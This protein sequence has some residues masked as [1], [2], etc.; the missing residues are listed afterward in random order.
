MRFLILVVT[1]LAGL[2]GGYWFI[3]RAAVANG[4]TALVSDLQ[5]RGW[6]VS[7]A[8]MATMG[9]PS[10]FDT[11]V[12]DLAVTDPATGAGW[13]APLFQVFALSYRPN[14]V[15]A[16]WPETQVIALPGQDV[17][18]TAADLRASAAVNASTDLAL[19]AVT[20]EG[21][22]IALASDLGWTAA[23]VRGLF[24]FRAAGPGPADYDLFTEATDLTLPAGLTARIDP[25]GTMPGVVAML[26]IDS[27]LTLDRP[28][29]RHL[30][31]QAAL[32]GVNLREMQLNWGTVTLTGNGTLTIDEAGVPDGRITLG[33]RNW[34]RLIALAVAA[35]VLDAGL[36]PTIGNVA[37][38][39]AAGGDTVS[40]PLSFQGGFMALGPLPLGPAPR[41]K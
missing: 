40:L 3:G 21:E 24:A 39:L 9:F 36:A 6:D 35:G 1:V 30:T 15:I 19:D 29:D 31:G 7:Y 13:Q 2:Y 41:F 23:L 38:A 37:T 11:T 25:Y 4:A 32:R 22:A 10:R 14:R 28:L 27:G 12:T 20:V 16:V 26:R 34:E 33:V 17:T 18:V 8:G 5:A